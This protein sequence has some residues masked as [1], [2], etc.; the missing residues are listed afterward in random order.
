MGVT[1][2]SITALR[3]SSFASAMDIHGSPS[4]GGSLRLRNARPSPQNS[5]SIHVSRSV[6]STDFEALGV[7]ISILISLEQFPDNAGE[8]YDNNNDDCPEDDSEN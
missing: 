1:L 8:L 6:I 2:N 7:N 4:N 5:R 3:V